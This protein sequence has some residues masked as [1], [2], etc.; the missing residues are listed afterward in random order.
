MGII[1]LYDV[2]KSYKVAKRE[3]SFLKQLLFHRYDEIVAVQCIN[4]QLKLVKPLGL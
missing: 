3:R 4:L 2:K 1:E